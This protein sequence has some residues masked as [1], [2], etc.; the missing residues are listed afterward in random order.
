M[1]PNARSVLQMP[2]GPTVEFMH[3]VE[4]ARRYSSSGP[5]SCKILLEIFHG[6]PSPRGYYSASFRDP[7][8]LRLFSHNTRFY[9]RIT[10]TK[11]AR[12]KRLSA[13]EKSI[14]H[15]LVNEVKSKISVA[16]IVGRSKRAMQ[17]ALKPSKINKKRYEEK[18]VKKTARSIVRRAVIG[19]FSAKKFKNHFCS[20]LFVRT[21]QMLIHRTFY[22]EHT[23]L[24]ISVDFRRLQ[25]SEFIGAEKTASIKSMVERFLL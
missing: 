11:M 4:I 13:S 17:C 15:D 23:R 22:L 5:I 1:E 24:K 9:Y 6:R 20:V 2:S 7:S 8:C 3:I 14:I 18:S 21:V 25:I 12:G 19:D 10:Y 16:S